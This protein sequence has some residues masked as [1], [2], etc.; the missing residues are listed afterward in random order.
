MRGD[1]D[2]TALYHP[3]PM[4]PIPLFANDDSTDAIPEVKDFD[5]IR[6]LRFPGTDPKREV[7]A[8]SSGPEH[9][10]TRPASGLTAI[11]RWFGAIERSESESATV[12]S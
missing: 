3:A 10:V 8:K 4:N 1:V 5:A 6:W 2:I 12:G 11:P 7:F 9:V